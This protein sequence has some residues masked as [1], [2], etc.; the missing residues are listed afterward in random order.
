[1]FGFREKIDFCLSSGTAAVDGMLEYQMSGF[2]YIA[3]NIH[4][5]DAVQDATSDRQVTSTP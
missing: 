1:M 4:P 5:A 2:T 3:A